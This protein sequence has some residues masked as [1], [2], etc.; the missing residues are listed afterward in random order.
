MDLESPLRTIASPV[1]AEVLRVLAGADIEFSASQV[2]RLAPAGSNFGVRKA[3]SRL[4]DA[5]LVLSRSHGN[6]ATW[7]GNRLH[8]LWPAIEIAVNARTELLARMR[9]AVAEHEALTAYVYGSFARRDSSPQSDIDLLLIHRDDVDDESMIDI[10]YDLTTRIE[11]WTGNPG[12]A[13][14]V[15]RSYLLGMLRAGDPIVTSFR[16]DAQALVGVEFG[17]L[18]RDLERDDAKHG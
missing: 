6:T 17:Q 12:Q 15:T 5:G 11:V 3:L 18:L 10:A 4:A 7:Q 14:N 13:F 1:E 16:Q 9:A 8:I 2:H